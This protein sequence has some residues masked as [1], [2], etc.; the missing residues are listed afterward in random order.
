[1]QPASKGPSSAQIVQDQAQCPHLGVHGQPWALPPP[2][3]ASLHRN[4]RH[5][6]PCPSLCLPR[7]H[8]HHLSVTPRV[9]NDRKTIDFIRTK[10]PVQRYQADLAEWERN[11]CK[12]EIRCQLSCSSDL[13]TR[14]FTV[15]PGHPTPSSW[16]LGLLFPLLGISQR[17]AF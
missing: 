13:H 8:T 9:R 4:S 6:A 7:L 14:D 11:F 1:M 5:H 16:F 2:P 12:L 3:C 17:E 10:K 15:R